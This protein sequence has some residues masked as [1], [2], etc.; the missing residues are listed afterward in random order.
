MLLKAGRVQ[1]QGGVQNQVI[2]RTMKQVYRSQ[3]QKQTTR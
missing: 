1:N 3:V 2:F